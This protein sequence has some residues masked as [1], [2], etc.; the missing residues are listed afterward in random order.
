MGIVWE[1][2][3][4]LLQRRVAVKE[5]PLPANGTGLHG[6]ADVVRQR[7][8]REA[9]VAARVNSPRLVTIF[10]VVEDERS[11]F[12]VQEFVDAPTLTELVEQ[13]GRL[14][15]EE[16]ASI[17]EQLVDGLEAL[18]SAGVVHRD[19]KPS[20]VMVLGDGTVKLTDYGVAWLTGDP[21]LTGSGIVLGSTGYLAPEQ[22]QG[23][24][25]DE[26]ADLWSLGATLFFAVDGAPPYQGSG[27]PVLTKVVHGAVP[28][29]AHAGPIA[30]VIAGLMRKDPQARIRGAEL[31]E[32]LQAVAAGDSWRSAG[33]DT[34]SFDPTTAVPVPVPVEQAAA[35]EPTRLDEAV[36]V[37]LAQDDRHL[38]RAVA[39]GDRRTPVLAIATAVVA[40]LLVAGLVAAV[41]AGGDDDDVAGRTTTTSAPAAAPTTA[42]GPTTSAAAD[43]KPRGGEDAAAA[44]APDGWAT[45]TDDRVGYR[46]AHPAGWQVRKVDSTRTDFVEPGTGSYLRVDWT[47]DPGPSAK[48]AWE[49]QSAGFGDRHSGYREIGIE[50]VDYRGYDAALWEYT[51]DARNG[52]LHAY[53]LGFVTGDHGFALNF[54]T[55]E[56]R[57]PAA[58]ATWEQLKAS[59]QPPS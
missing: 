3:D 55:A 12:L 57:W 9:K 47:D 42:T 49:E 46:V 34:A 29:P 48:K 22:A 41:R 31:R 43:E 51:Y 4:L 53:N 38:G 10:D 54:Q 17:G 56:S 52:R 13:D 7:A 21:E 11:V 33:E 18:H 50:E 44:P 25:V 2:E 19:L 27:I 59:F 20:N 5:V 23:E 8:L 15:P 35:V 32:R 28:V 26:S 16:T 36:D 40:L 24:R 39:T 37:G 45:Y 6:D 1:A 14:S 30:P 58:Q